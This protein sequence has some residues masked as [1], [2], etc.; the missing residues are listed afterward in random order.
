MGRMEELDRMEKADLTITRVHTVD[1][2]EEVQMQVKE[3]NREGYLKENIFVLTHDKSRTKRIAE[4]TDAAEIGIDE[5]GLIT[6]I[7]N[8]F[9][10]TDE[11]LK[12]KMRSL[13]ISEEECSRLLKDME[14][15][16]IVV[17]A[18]GGREYKDLDFDRSI[19]YHPYLGHIG[20]HGTHPN[21]PGHIR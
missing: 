14:E 5:E 11:E 10:S 2:H 6:T 12:A 18:W 15:D 4:K 1:S 16:R 9:R 3:F 20:H 19:Y 13:G 21:H 8:I 17:I 7:A